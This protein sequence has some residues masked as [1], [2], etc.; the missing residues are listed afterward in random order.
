[1]KPYDFLKMRYR[2]F[3]ETD[4]KIQYVAKFRNGAHFFLDL[5]AHLPVYELTVFPVGLTEDQT[6]PLDLKVEITIGAIIKDFLIEYENSI[7]YI[8]DTNDKR[9]S[10]RYRKFNSWYSRQTNIVFTKVDSTF[11]IRDI[12]IFASLIVHESNLF[13]D[14]IIELFLAQKEKRLK[15]KDPDT[16]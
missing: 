15:E 13:F 16:E 6:P 9:A 1:M 11:F 10:V 4:N 7:L 5:P 14:E 3:F 2:Y 8:C 12:E